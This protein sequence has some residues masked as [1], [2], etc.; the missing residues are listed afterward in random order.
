MK[1]LIFLFLF[2]PSIVFG[3]GLGGKIIDKTLTVTFTNSDF[4]DC[5]AAPTFEVYEDETG[6]AIATG[7]MAK[8]NDAGTTGFYSELLTLSTGNGYEIG[9]S[10][11]I[12]ME[13][14]V[15]TTTRQGTDT[16]DVVADIESLVDDIGVAGAGLTDL[17]GMSTGMKAEVNTEADTAL[18][19]YDA[20]ILSDF[21]IISGTADSGSTTTIGDSLFSSAEAN[22]Y[23]GSIVL[24][25]GETSIVSGFNAGTDTITF[26]PALSSTA[27]GQAYS[28]F[29]ASLWEILFRSRLP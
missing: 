23:I 12:L 1:W 27:S 10:Y 17:G 20:T 7:S 9:K 2:L 5:D 26:D 25:T 24:V 14:A 19:D 8:L 18:T 11:S 15:S 13:C 4:V 29:P 21:G 28:L 22:A 6:T 3:D 16:W